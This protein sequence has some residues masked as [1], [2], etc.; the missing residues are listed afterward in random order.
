[1]KPLPI[2]AAPL[3][4][5]GANLPAYAQLARLSRRVTY[6]YRANLI[7]NALSILIQVYLLKVIWTAL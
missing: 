3:A 7:F 6:V 1:M 4:R 5:V 2:R